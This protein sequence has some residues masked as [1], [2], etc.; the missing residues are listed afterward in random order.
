MPCAES[1]SGPNI[2]SVDVFLYLLS[3]LLYFYMPI[4]RQF[5]SFSF[6]FPIYCTFICLCV[7]IN[8]IILLTALVLL[9]LHSPRKSSVGYFP[10][11]SKI[12]IVGECP[13]QNQEG[14][15]LYHLF[16]SFPYPYFIL[17]FILSC[18]TY[19]FKKN[20]LFH[21]S[22]FF[23]SNLFLLHYLLLLSR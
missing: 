22:F 2:S 10:K 13:V 21:S 5:I 15:P 11:G 16:I 19:R 20:S 8:H 3:Y 1:R 12:L 23:F 6:Y 14:V 4:Y 17:L 9:S 18:L 7:S